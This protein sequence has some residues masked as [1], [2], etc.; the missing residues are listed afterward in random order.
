MNPPYIQSLFNTFG[1]SLHTNV[2]EI[3]Y[4]HQKIL[5]AYR[6]KEISASPKLDIH[7][8]VMEIYVSVLYAQIAIATFF[9]ADFRSSTVVEKRLNLKY[10]SFVST[11]FFK[12]V[13]IIGKNNT[14]WRKLES[15]LL[16][17]NQEK[18]QK[19]VDE[20]NEKVAEFRKTYF[21][22]GR[23]NIALH[24]DFDLDKVYQ[25]LCEID[26]EYEAKHII[27]ILSILQPLSIV[28]CNYLHVAYPEYNLPH[29]IN[30]SDIRKQFRESLLSSIYD[31]IGSGLQS[32]AIRLDQN[33]STYHLIDK[34]IVRD[35]LS[36]DSLSQIKEFRNCFNLGVL[37][38]YFYLDLGTAV[39]GCL[40]SE[41][42]YEQ[43]LH[44][45]RI[46]VIVYEGFKKIFL[47]KSNDNSNH[48]L[49]GKY[50]H[51]PLLALNDTNSITEM[52]DVELAL[53]DYSNNKTI[54][55]IRHKYSHFRKN[56]H[57]YLIDLWDKVLVSEPIIELNKALD[58]LQLINRIIRLN[59]ISL[60]YF[61]QQEQK[62]EYNKLLAP[63]DDVFV[64]ALCSC[65][66]TESREN[67][68]KI[69]NEFRSKILDAFDKMTKSLKNKNNE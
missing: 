55:D 43:Q 63:L 6:K 28:C 9:R 62:M 19:I 20:I 23:R 7:I 40:I 12:A 68:N 10:L 35:L 57:L 61:A 15:A 26:E 22:S 39:R 44:A 31:R 34:P 17:E 56:N 25:H 59:Q 45:L 29:A 33:M 65:K 46:N 18:H 67:L 30:E 3:T 36:E 41:N 21:N 1:I 51:I 37:L 13:F 47:P 16:I 4:W 8:S 54:E 32:F 14:L 64:K 27:S 2:Q 24:Y 60:N 42:Y 53:Q 48:S 69:K 66:T 52:K 38:H 5:E 49:W 50:V 58:F 11:E